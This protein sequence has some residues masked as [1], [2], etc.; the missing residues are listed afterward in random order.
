MGL[1]HERS[2]VRSPAS[3]PDEN[4]VLVGT[5]P[6]MGSAVL[7][8]CIQ[9]QI[10]GGV[11]FVCKLFVIDKQRQ[12]LLQQQIDAANGTATSWGWAYR[13]LED[14]N[15]FYSINCSSDYGSSSCCN[16]HGS[17]YNNGLAGTRP[18]HHGTGSNHYPSTAVTS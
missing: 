17:R 5:S 1:T 6:G 12:V 15:S 8:S 18:Y 11:T 16:Y 7:G 10:H 4:P 2:Q 14:Q 3:T 9:T 13:F